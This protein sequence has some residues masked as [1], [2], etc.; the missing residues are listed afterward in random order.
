EAGD[1][2]ARIKI[3]ATLRSLVALPPADDDK[4]DGDRAPAL[5][6]TATFVWLEQLIAEHL[7]LLFP[8]LAIRGAYPF[9]VLRDAD[10]GL[11]LGEA[12]DLLET[13]EQGLQKQ[14]FGSVVAV[15]IQPTM[16]ERVRNI[17]CENLEIAPADLIELDGPLGLGGLPELLDLDRPDLR[18]APLLARVPLEL[19]RGHDPFAAIQHSALLLHHPSGAL[20]S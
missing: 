10:L 15:L 16:P 19:R 20:S 7:D 9:R 8:G 2:F 18:D 6:P 11:Q 13:V 4:R 3:P 1:L 14:R 12:G 5:L 17:L